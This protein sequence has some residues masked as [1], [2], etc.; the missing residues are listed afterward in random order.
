MYKKGN[1]SK[2][3]KNTW[4]KLQYFKEKDKKL[5]FQSAQ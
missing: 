2:K 4:G 5:N 3:K 1:K